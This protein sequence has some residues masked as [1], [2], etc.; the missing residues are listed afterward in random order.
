MPFYFS[1]HTRT[2]HTRSGARC[3][4]R[5]S[6]NRFPS[7]RQRLDSLAETSF[8]SRR[9]SEDSRL[10]LRESSVARGHGDELRSTFIRQ[11]LAALWQCFLIRKRNDIRMA[12]ECVNIDSMEQLSMG[13]SSKSELSFL[14]A[15]ELVF[16]CSS[17]PSQKPSIE[18]HH[19]HPL[20]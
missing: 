10:S 11:H 14:Q 16:V 9:E 4:T 1:D 5:V 2:S 15:S 6:Q 17:L 12:M 20:Q 19:V 8:G 18:L 3:K 7:P 13:E